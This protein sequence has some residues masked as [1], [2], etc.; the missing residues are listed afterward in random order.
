MLEVGEYDS[1]K[2]RSVSASRRRSSGRRRRETTAFQISAENPEALAA[3]GHRWSKSRV[4]A[5]DPGG[6]AA[7][8]D[9]PVQALR[10][11]EG[12][13]QGRAHPHG[14][15]GKGSLR[16]AEAQVPTQ[17]ALQALPEAGNDPGKRQEGPEPQ[18][19]FRAHQGRAL[20][21]A[22]YRA[23]L[24]ATDSLGAKSKPKRLTF[25]IV[26]P[27]RLS[28]R[29]GRESPANTASGSVRCRCSSSECRKESCEQG[30]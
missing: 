10:G 3:N 25:R 1:P 8:Y 5:D 16:E 26:R 19:L 28:L 20:H 21:R 17:A 4:I 12:P 23:T 11:R 22:R 7:R 15:A 6:S 9:L 18:A 27:W 14:T 29:A 2:L 13:D 30:R 24:V